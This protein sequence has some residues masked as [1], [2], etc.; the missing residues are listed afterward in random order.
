MIEMLSKDVNKEGR[1]EGGGLR[2][3]RRGEMKCQIKTGTCLLPLQAINH[4]P[5]Q[6]L[7]FNTL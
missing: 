2:I 7:T 1:K 3:R 6:P 4:E 5:L